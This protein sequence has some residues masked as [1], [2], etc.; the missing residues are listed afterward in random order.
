MGT[1]QLFVCCSLSND[2]FAIA[3]VDLF[4]ALSLSLTGHFALE[5]HSPSLNIN[6]DMILVKK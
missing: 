4:A 5:Q 3:F 1:L 2:D 6:I